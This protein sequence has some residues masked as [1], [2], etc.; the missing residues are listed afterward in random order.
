MRITGRYTFGAPIE[1][2]WALLMDV[3]ALRE[4]VPGC[5]A[6]EPLGG[7]RY[8][9]SLTVGV[10]SITGSYEGV[11]QLADLEP[12]SSYR[13][14]VEGSGRPGFV[15]GETR[16]TLRADDSAT[17]VEVEADVQVGGAIARVG[18][19]LLGSVSKMMMDRFF[20]CLQRKAAGE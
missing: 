3:G 11:V 12:P 6:L 7:D 16:V 17:L 13:L 9:A 20:A 5:E 8:R 14:I 4:C 2:V 15:K 1:S 18:Q 10:A 19:R